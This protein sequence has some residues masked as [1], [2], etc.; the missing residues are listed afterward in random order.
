MYAMNGIEL[1]QR[2]IEHYKQEINYDYIKHEMERRIKESSNIIF[3]NG[4]QSDSI[5]K[6]NTAKSNSKRKVEITGN[7]N[8]A[9]QEREER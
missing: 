1:L 2:E 8:M 6:M 5:N 9:I 3:Q 7:D 4:Q